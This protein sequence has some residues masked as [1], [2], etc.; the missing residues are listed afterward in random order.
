MAWYYILIGIQPWTI[1]CAH[2]LQFST[3]QLKC[4]TLKITTLN[5]VTLNERYCA[6]PNSMFKGMMQ[7]VLRT[8]LNLT[9]VWQ[10]SPIMGSGSEHNTECKWTST[11]A[12]SH[13]NK[14]VYSSDLNPHLHIQ[15]RQIYILGRHTVRRR[16]LDG[17]KCTQV[18]PNQNTDYHHSYIRRPICHLIR[19]QL[20]FYTLSGP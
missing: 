3:V 18:L 1:A 15:I 12:E 11:L 2:H 13:N 16:P 6:Q 5:N 9:N 7:L 19:L 20:Y 8:E 14:L 10:Q 4:L 17:Q